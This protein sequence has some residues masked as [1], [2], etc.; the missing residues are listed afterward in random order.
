M[1]DTAKLPQRLARLEN[2]VADI[3]NMLSGIQTTLADHDRRFDR[4]DETLIEVL[5]RL[6]EA[7]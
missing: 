7:S 5:R 1:T 3:Y 2:D 6:P 4:I